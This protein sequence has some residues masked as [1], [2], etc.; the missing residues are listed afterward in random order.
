MCHKRDCLGGLI[1][2]LVCILSISG[3]RILINERTKSL[4]KHG[5]MMFC[6][7]GDDI[8]TCK[9]DLEIYNLQT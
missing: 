9:I 1:L 6:D 3:A 4:L 5:L 8:M 7:Y 2:H